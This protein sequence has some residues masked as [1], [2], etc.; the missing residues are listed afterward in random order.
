[1]IKQRG[2]EWVAETFGLEP[3][4]KEGPDIAKVE[5]VARKNLKLERDAC[6]NVTF[7]AKGAFNRLYKVETETGCSLMRVTLPVDPSNKTNSEV[8]TINFVRGITDIP[9]PRIYAFD[10]SSENEIGFEWIVMEM[11]PG[12]TLKSRWRKLSMDTK[13]ELVKQIAKYQAQLFRHKF[14]AIG[15]IFI[16][17]GDQLAS[18]E[19]P[20]GTVATGPEQVPLQSPESLPALGQLVSMSFFWGDRINQDVPRGLFTKSEDWIR[21]RLALVLSD[22]ERIIKTSS[23]EGEIEDAQAAKEIAQ[24]ALDLLPSMFPPGNTSPESSILFHDDLSMQNILIYED[25]KITGIVDWECVSTLPLWKASDFPQFLEGRERS[26]EPQR[27]QYSPE[28][29]NEDAD[30]LDEGALGN[31]GISGLYWEHLQDYELTILREVFWKEMRELEPR[32]IEEAEKG[33]G[34]ADFD[35]VVQYSDD[36][37]RTTQIKSWLDAR[38]KGETWSLKKIFFE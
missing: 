12:A 18:R 33:A 11:L 26:E 31:E 3:R 2:L 4:W 21:A 35:L 9:V 7:H 32:W 36:G 34:K 16:N 29:E 17:P 27:D 8:A 24:R 10:D 28:S 15:N 19:G 1:M 22:Q 25:G 6:C 13:G 20:R 38:E 14:P 23:D 30:G 37:W 5:P